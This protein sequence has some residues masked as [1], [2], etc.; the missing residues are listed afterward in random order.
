LQ[1]L[2]QIASALFGLVLF[3]AALI[4][5]SLILA[6][7]AVGALVLWGWIM[8]R[9]RHARRTGRA[10]ERGEKLVIEG[11]YVVDRDEGE[12]QGKD[13]KGPRP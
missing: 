13:A 7:A 11:E 1:K 9:S 10:T 4:F 8:W 2:T 6:V 5:T 12:P 3:A